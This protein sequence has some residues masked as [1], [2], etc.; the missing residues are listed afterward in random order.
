[1]TF[2]IAAVHPAVLGAFGLLA[3]APT[4]LAQ[5]PLGG[6]FTVNTY[7]AYSVAPAVSSAPD[8]R[9]V[10]VWHGNGR[11]DFVSVQ[12]RL[13]AG[14]GRPVGDQFRVNPVTVG[15]QVA[16]DVAMA[17]DGDFVS[18]WSDSQI[19]IQALRFS[20]VGQPVG[21]AI[22]L[23]TSSAS[24]PALA[25]GAGGFVAVYR[26]G[27]NVSMRRFD[28]A[29]GV[30]SG[31][32]TVSTLGPMDFVTPN[33][34]MAPGGGFIVV[35]NSDQSTGDDTSGSSVQARRYDV[36]GSPL[37]GQFQVN[38]STAGDQ[39]RP[40]VAAAG[41]GDF[42]VAWQD[43]NGGTRPKARLFSSDGT[44]LGGEIEVN[45]TGGDVS[46]DAAADGT[47]TVVWTQGAGS[48]GRTF[49]RGGVPF[50]GPFTVP[51]EPVNFDNVGVI[52]HDDRGRFVVA[53]Q[54][55]LY[56]E[57][58]RIAARRFTTTLFADDFESGGL[59]SWTAVIETP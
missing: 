31:P 29:T 27:S 46:I 20:S 10:V 32:E 15:Q 28:N 4:A 30:L 2:R 59:S 36:D 6:Q 34:D 11:D 38:L 12:G 56:S 19:G 51:S 42:I 57:F 24:A 17:P 33:V 58:Y 9:F 18:A 54:S 44:G 52:S 37:G 22:D 14:D 39:S 35:W 49:T 3:W 48:S 25:V 7:S 13:Y 53:W 41:N 40:D 47:F 8:G 43:A 23:S 50:F 16:A 1:M 26:A 45:G 5:G 21:G 55:N